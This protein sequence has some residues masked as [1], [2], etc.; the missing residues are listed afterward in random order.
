MQ[1]MTLTGHP[2]FSGC[3]LLAQYEKLWNMVFLS[4]GG[5]MGDWSIPES[6]RK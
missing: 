1:M 3:L 2:F 4:F 5:S 6:K